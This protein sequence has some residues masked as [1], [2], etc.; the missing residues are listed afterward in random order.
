MARAYSTVSTIG[1]INPS[2]GI[3]IADQQ[4]TLVRIGTN[5][6]GAADPAN[7]L[8]GNTHVLEPP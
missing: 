8:R 4:R 3:Q 2:P 7:D 6:C 5:D 1:T